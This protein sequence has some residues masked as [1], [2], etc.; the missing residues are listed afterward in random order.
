MNNLFKN[1]VVLGANGKIGQSFI[2]QL[3]KLNE[4]ESIYAFSRSQTNFNSQKVQ[5]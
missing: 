3:K 2:N 1:V 5:S 4:I